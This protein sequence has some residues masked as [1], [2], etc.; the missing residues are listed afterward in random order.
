MSDDR[1][2]EEFVRSLTRRLRGA[3]N[4]HRPRGLQSCGRRVV[5]GRDVHISHPRWVCLGNDVR[6]GDGV[7]LESAGGLAVGHGTR[8][9][10]GVTIGT[11]DDAPSPVR[12]YQPVLIGRG[13][14]IG[15]YARIGPGSRI[16]DGA[17]V[18]ARAVVAG[19]VG[20]L[21]PRP[22]DAG[23]PK[24]LFVFLPSTGR[25]GTTTM[26]RLLSRHPE[27]RCYHER[28]R[29]LIRLS[30]E[31]AHGI[32]DEAT[33][34][35]ELD[36]IY[37]WSGVYRSLVYG[38]SDHRLFNLLGLLDRLLPESRF[39]WLIRDGRDVVASTLARGWYGGEF[40]STTWGEYRLRGDAC[41]DV[42][43]AEW[44]AM[45]PFEKNCWYWAFVNRR[46]GA[47]LAELA[48]DRWMAL[49]LEDLASRATSLFEFIGVEPIEVGA[50]RENP[51]RRTVVPPERWGTSE[52]AAFDR[53]C[54]ETMN[55]WYDGWRRA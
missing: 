26:A 44:A 14:T 43:S 16:G 53:W 18:A 41:G 36:A 3:E 6:V 38:E 17:T 52:K 13:V 22:D 24:T 19:D 50:A 39:V 21:A 20:D 31:L 10:R 34:S 37:V 49:R 25:S 48:A 29:Q 23:I 33:A 7:R 28:R 46:I 1:R 45:T 12:P 9:G 47:Q 5:I 51:S 8:I 4:R 15:D 27:I 11:T 55:T 40:R 54:G 35:A 2:P 32:V 30:T 42:S